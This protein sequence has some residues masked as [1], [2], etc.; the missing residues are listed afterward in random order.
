MSISPKFTL[1]PGWAKIPDHLSIG[2]VS[3]VAIDDAQ[4]VWI[5]HRYE[6]SDA[7]SRRPEPPELPWEDSGERSHDDGRRTD[8]STVEKTP[9]PPV[10]EFDQDG[11]YLRGWGGPS[12]SYE[13]PLTEHS[14]HVD[15]KGYVWLTSAKGDAPPG[16]N[17][18]LKFTRDGDFV[19]QIGRRGGCK[20]GSHDKTSVDGAAD[21]F[22]YART[23]E[24][25]VADGYRNRRVVVFEADTGRFLRMWGAYGNVPDDS[26]P[27][28]WGGYGIEGQQFRTV[29]GIRVSDDDRVYVADR[30]NNRVQIFD[31]DGHFLAEVF[32]DRDSKKIGT[33]FAIAFSSDPGQKYMYVPDGSNGV[34]HVFD[35]LNL[36]ELDTF[37]SFG[38][39]EGQLQ[40]AHSIACD[41]AGNVYTTEVIYQKRIQKWILEPGTG[42]A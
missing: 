33:A 3:G 37:G 10:M 26:V 9:A 11:N 39:D 7:G 25:F 23:N 24:L 35:R 20:D 36:V 4:H 15:Y 5:I 19:L 28:G 2:D 30:R 14:M 34:V 17:Q 29:H 31:L 41:A 16:E 6:M 38:Q 1:Q 13:W 42:T 32:I 27:L 8:R 21:V 18:I 22:V 40:F 12:E